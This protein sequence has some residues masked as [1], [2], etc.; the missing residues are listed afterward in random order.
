MSKSIRRARVNGVSYYLN[1]EAGGSRSGTRFYLYRTL[2]NG[3]TRDGRVHLGSVEG[4]TLA[5]V[6]GDIAF[7][8]A[9]QVHFAS[10]KVRMGQVRKTISGPTGR[11][12][13]EA[14]KARQNM[15]GA[16]Q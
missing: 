16:S 11:W 7:F 2:D 5:A 12:E 3:R 4:H 15:Q 8:E 10:K 6:V 14:F 9:C 13:G 1:Q